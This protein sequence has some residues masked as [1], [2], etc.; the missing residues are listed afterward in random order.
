MTFCSLADIRPSITAKVT[1]AAYLSASC[2]RAKMD[3]C[4]GRQQQMSISC[5]TENRR[6]ITHHHKGKMQERFSPPRTRWADWWGLER[7]PV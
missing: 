3:R 6:G 5:M 4:L 2:L 1:L 7:D